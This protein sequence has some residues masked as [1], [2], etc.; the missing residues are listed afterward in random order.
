MIFRYV[1]L[2]SKRLAVQCDLDHET[3]FRPLRVQM[4]E[5]A[6]KVAVFVCV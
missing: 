2:L 1:K 3:P 4:I 5:D 6:R